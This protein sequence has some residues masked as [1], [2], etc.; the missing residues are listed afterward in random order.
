M[1]ELI[2]DRLTLN[3][4][5]LPP[6]SYRPRPAARRATAE[7][8]PVGTVRSWAG[9][10]AI[11]NDVYRKDYRL[12][13][14]GE[15]IEVWVADDLAFP[16][17]DCRGD[18][19]QVTDAQIDALV[20]EFDETIYPKETAAFSRPPDRTG[21]N[22]G[23]PDDFSGA[24]ERT[25][26]LVDNVRDENY[27]NFL[28]RPTYVAGFF[29]EQ[30]NELFDRNVVTIDAYDWLHQTG[31][32]PKNEPTDDRCTS[33]PARPRLYESTFAH[34][35]QHLLAYYVDATEEDWVSEGLAEYAQ[36][37]VGY[38]DPSI[39]VYRRGFDPHIACYQGFGMVKTA[40]NPN[41]R[42][43][44]APANSLNLWKEGGPNE[45]LAD[46][47]ITYQLMIYLHD[48]FG[49]EIISTLHRDSTNKGLSGIAA[50]LPKGTDLHDVLHDF[51]IMTLVDKAVGQPGGVMKGLP[52][53]HVTAPGLRSTVNLADTS[54]YGAPGAAPN[55]ADYVRLPRD[56]RSVDFRGADTLPPSP[57]LWTVDSGMLF[58]GNEP[59]TDATAVRMVDVPAIDP[60]LRFTSTHGLEKDFDY[61]Y[62]TVSA[63][64]GKTYQ[65]V[66]GDETVQGP[67]GAAITGQAADVTLSYDLAAY[68]GRSVLLG[69]RYVSDGAVSLGGWHVKD[70]KIGATA[71]DSDTL[72]GWNSPTQIRPTP[73]HNWHVTLV[74]LGR[75]RAKAVSLDEL[76]K[77]GS[78][79]RVIA[80]IAYDE[81]TGEV[82]Q[83]APYTLT[84]NGQ[85]YPVSDAS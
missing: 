76:A 63:D 18:A 36:T 16:E 69:F 30:L 75:S 32:E 38:V 73:V 21:A 5:P 64:G 74:G 58:S 42:D 8:P 82:T 17:G 40:Y 54:A 70:V 47:G 26:T 77:L 39:N 80:V 67:L 28:E 35:W 46:Y 45:I 34:E 11:T 10:N 78:Y 3:G 71:V 13:A 22:A 49:P 19:T 2:P 12:R 72:D 52:R 62:V 85:P 51:Q 81:P 9:L 61:G 31:A 15:Y 44:N 48:R 33:R 25:V 56:L 53:E 7:T 29:S 1:R 66:T 50:A 83:Y 27:F 37:L 43:C 65:P 60:V 4:E 14:V 55:G 20:R 68:A 41:P 6:A 84:V 79:P 59:D 24:G 57:L 23:L